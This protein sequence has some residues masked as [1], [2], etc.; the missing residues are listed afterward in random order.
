MLPKMK[1]RTLSSTSA[2]SEALGTIERRIEPRVRVDIAARFKCLN[3][4][5]S[6]GP[7][8]RA[9]I[10]EVSY[11]GIRLRVG[12]E[13]PPGGLVQIIVADK[14]LMGT[15]RHVQREGTEFLLGIHLTERIPSCLA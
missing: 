2:L 11:H 5:M 9:T 4:L 12:R 6:T 1:P 15:V 13:V 10:T 7:S 8:S 14:I 3:P